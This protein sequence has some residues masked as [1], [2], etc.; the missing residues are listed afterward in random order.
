METFIFLA[1]AH[2]FII[3]TIFFF[4]V[5]IIYD[6]TGI[7]LISNIRDLVYLMP[8]FTILFFIFILV[9]TGIP[10]ILN[11]LGEFMSLAG[12]FKINP[13]TA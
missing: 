9:N 11:Y 6:R 1:I 13:I 12:I 2:G 8:I 7:H 3:L 5:S 10:L 4:V